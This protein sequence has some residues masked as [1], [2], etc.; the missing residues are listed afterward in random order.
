MEIKDSI[1]VKI[2]YT[3][4]KILVQVVG[5]EYLIFSPWSETLFSLPIQFY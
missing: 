4:S 3:E 5:L 2:L 1:G